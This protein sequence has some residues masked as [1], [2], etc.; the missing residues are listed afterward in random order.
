MQSSAVEAVRYH[1]ATCELDVRFE[2]GREYRY[3]KV[4]RSKFHALMA[5]DSIGA[6]V[7]EEIKPDHRYSEIT[8][9][10]RVDEILNA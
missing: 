5:A 7:N 3:E 9:H 10:P 1:P 4:P 2:E 6:F 8:P